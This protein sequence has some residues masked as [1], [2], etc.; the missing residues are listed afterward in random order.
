MTNP[1]KKLTERQ[2][3]LLAKMGHDISE[4]EKSTASSGG[5]NLTKSAR[6]EK[7]LTELNGNT[8]E[9]TSKSDGEEKLLLAEVRQLRNKLDQARKDKMDK[10]MDG[11]SSKS[12]RILKHLEEFNR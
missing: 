7:Y 1:K 8:A 11:L 9:D 6:I 4:I 2:K 12:Q 10:S 5:G 3:E